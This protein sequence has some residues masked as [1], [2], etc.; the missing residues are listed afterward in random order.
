MHNTLITTV[1]L[2]LKSIKGESKTK[3]IL[4]R[5]NLR[6]TSQF[7]ITQLVFTLSLQ[8]YIWSLISKLTI[9]FINNN[10]LVTYSN[11]DGRHFV[12]PLNELYIKRFLLANHNILFLYFL[13]NKR[14]I[15]FEFF[16][17]FQSQDVWFNLSRW[18]S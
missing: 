15:G 7:S 10:F 3:M 18:I 12:T 14:I 2:K 6:S 9:K 17:W 11:N 5:S 13:I 16:I 8:M 4:I 1:K